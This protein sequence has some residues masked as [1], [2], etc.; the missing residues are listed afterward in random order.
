[1]LWGL[2]CSSG[3]METASHNFRL[4][5]VETRRVISSMTKPGGTQIK[6]NKSNQSV[7]FLTNYGN[8]LLFL[9]I[10]L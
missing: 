4:S 5:P 2:N 3:A 6:L 9:V 8:V 7:R 1:M 10:H